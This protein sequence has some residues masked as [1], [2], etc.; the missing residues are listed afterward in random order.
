VAT[1]VCP[2]VVSYSNLVVVLPPAHSLARV[3]ALTVFPPFPYA[4]RDNPRR[5][6]A[7]TLQYLFSALMSKQNT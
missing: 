1:V 5:A 6:P 2:S 3:L 4:V 7:I